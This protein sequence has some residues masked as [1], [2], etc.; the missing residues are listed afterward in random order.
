MLKLFTIVLFSVA[1]SF[2][3]QATVALKAQAMVE[4]GVIRLGQIAEIKGDK[5]IIDKI[6]DLEVGKVTGPGRKTRVTE[7]AIKSF[8]I[9]S[10]A[11]NKDVVFNGAKF[12]DITARS[13]LVSA[14]SV[15]SLL[16]SEVRSRMNADLQEG[17]D[18]IFE[19]SKV[20]SL[21]VPESG[22]TISVS[23]SPQFAG[24]GQEMAIVQVFNGKKVIS[25]HSIPYTVKRFEYV[26]ELKNGIRKN[27]VIG[28]NDFKMVWQETTFQKRKVIKKAEEAAGR[29]ALR[30][31]KAG[32][33]L[34]DNALIAPYA[35]K[36]GEMVKVF[37][38]IGST[39]VQTT[40]LAQ[41]NAFKGQTISFRNIDSGK[42]I[43][44]TVSGTREAWV[45]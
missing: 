33:L 15:K 23:L 18:W 2:S 26:A 24:I 41:K 8:F 28:E 1:F 12:S 5:E 34:V 7:N 4:P 13:G 31:L 6:S 38:Q 21:S 16:L 17:K 25:K 19:V 11:N 20:P 10:V 29:T 45:R 39:V 37:A 42:D 14:D 3:A 36:E 27:E 35:V 40:A 22:G 30:T 44:A 43:S 32:E 9:K